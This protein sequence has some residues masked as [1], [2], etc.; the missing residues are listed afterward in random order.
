MWW[1]VGFSSFFSSSSSACLPLPRTFE[2]TP[3]FWSA[4]LPLEETLVL[5]FLRA[6]RVYCFDLLGVVIKFSTE[7]LLSLSVGYVDMRPS[8]WDELPSLPLFSFAWISLIGFIWDKILFDFH[9]VQR[10]L[11][12]LQS[13][14]SPIDHQKRVFKAARTRIELLPRPM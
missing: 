12:S 13:S 9:W 8:L 11:Y 10:K 1:L 14:K 5:A 3:I 4:L 7:E 2:F 6:D